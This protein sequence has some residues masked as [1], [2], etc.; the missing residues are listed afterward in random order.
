[1]RLLAQTVPVVVDAFAAPLA[2]TR[3]S[4]STQ[5]VAPR[6]RSARPADVIVK[7]VET[8][9]ADWSFGLGRAQFLHGEL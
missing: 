7:V 5:R 1:M 6:S 4:P 2:A 9:R 8:T 3:S